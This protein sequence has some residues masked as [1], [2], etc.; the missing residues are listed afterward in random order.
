[1]ETT[2][3]RGLNQK[4][5]QMSEVSTAPTTLPPPP[6]EG[7]DVVGVATTPQGS[8]STFEGDIADNLYGLTCVDLKFK[9]SPDKF[10]PGKLRDQIVWLFTVD[11]HEAKGN[12]AFYT[13]FSLHEKSKLPSTTA[14]LGHPAQ[15]GQPIKKSEYVGKK[16]KGLIEAVSR[17]RDGQTKKYAKITKLLKA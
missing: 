4:E 12:L 13:S 9:R 15:D 6:A 2:A 16:C 1:M 11:G 14:A 5:K 7:D 3:L 17:E 8:D 10:N